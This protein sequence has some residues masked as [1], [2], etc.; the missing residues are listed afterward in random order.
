VLKKLTSRDARVS[1]VVGNT[2][3]FFI[4]ASRARR[5]PSTFDFFLFFPQQLRHNGFHQGLEE[6][7]WQFTT[8][9]QSK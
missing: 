2:E 8:E 1:Q 3:G 9:S 5:A 4:F 6:D 7:L